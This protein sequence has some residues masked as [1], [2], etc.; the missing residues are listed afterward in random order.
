MRRFQKRW[1]RIVSVLCIIIVIA[2]FSIS[3]HVKKTGMSYIIDAGDATKVDAVV[4]L[5]ARVFSDGN[6]S[7]MLKDRLTVGYE[8]YIQ[9]KAT[10]IIVS[11]DHGR[12]DYDEVNTMKAYLMEKGIPAEDIF[13]D[14]AGFSTYESIYRARDIFLADKIIIVTQKYHLMRAIYIAKQLGLEAYGVASD[15]HV[16]NG[17]MLKNEIRE[18]AARNKDYFIAKFIQPKPTYLGDVIPVTGDGRLTDD[19]LVD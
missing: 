4:I 6:V 10:K 1:I 15:I 2:V 12:K 8:L 17:V 3:Q 13:M 9:K 5:G 16:Y 14:H 19:N 18:I 11:G 7:L